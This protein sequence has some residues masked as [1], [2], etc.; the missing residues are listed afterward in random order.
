MVQQSL[1]PLRTVVEYRSGLRRE[2][3]EQLIQLGERLVRR[4]R[5]AGAVG[6]ERFLRRIELANDTQRLSILL[7][8]GYRRGP[9]IL[10]AFV[11]RPDD[12]RWRCHLEICAEEVHPIAEPEPV[13]AAGA[14]IHLAR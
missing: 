8:Q 9:A 13:S 11:V 7:G 6:V 14:H 10:S 12:E 4:I 2:L 5:R 1:P 3:D